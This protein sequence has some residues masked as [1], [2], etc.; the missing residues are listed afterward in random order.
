MKQK[1]T[2]G[3]WIEKRWS[4]ESIILALGVTSKNCI[5]PFVL[6]MNLT[7][8][9]YPESSSVRN[10]NFVSLLPHTSQL[11][12][13]SCQ[14]CHRNDAT[15]RII[16]DRPLFQNTLKGVSLWAGFWKMQNSLEVCKKR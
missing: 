15:L 14:S 7:L 8:K 5:T 11:K 12:V 9:T 2:L 10:Q 13:R 16:Q 4:V 1:R 3:R 6:E